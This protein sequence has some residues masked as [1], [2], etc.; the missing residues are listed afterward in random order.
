MQVAIYTDVG[1]GELVVHEIPTC[2]EG[3][4]PLGRD[5]D[6]AVEAKGVDVGV[7]GDAH[8]SGVGEGSRISE[9]VAERERPWRGPV[10]VSVGVAKD[11]IE[12]VRVEHA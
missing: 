7:R 1:V 12:F 6:V 5:V 10:N 11:F 9:V 8:K 2:R 3:Y 4:L